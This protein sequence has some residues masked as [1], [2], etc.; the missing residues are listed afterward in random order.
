ME[1]VVELIGIRKSFGG[2]HALK[3]VD[4]ALRRGEVHALL[5]ENGAGKSTLMRVLGGEYAAEGGCVKMAGNE[6]Q[7]RGPVDALDKGIAI[8]HQEMALATDLTVAENI[9]LSE[10]PS[11]ISWRDLNRRAAKLIASL[12]FSISPSAVVSD[13][14]LAH[15]Q[16]VEIAKALSRN[17]SVMVFDEPTAVLSVQDAE[18]LLGIIRTLRDRGVGVI[19]IS[20]RLDEVF[21]IADRI[22]VMKDGASVS[23]VER[24]DVEIDDV[25]RMMVGRSLKALFGEDIDRPIGEEVLRIENLSDGRRIG[26]V[27]LTIKAGEIVGLGG[28]VGAGRTELVRMIFGAEK[29]HSGKIFLHGRQ[30]HINNP[31]AAVKAGIGLVPESRKEQGLVLDFPIRVNAT[32]SRL[33][34]LVNLFGFV[35]RA[36]ETATVGNLAARLR[37]KAGSL[38]DPASSLS[39]GNQQKVVLAKW[40]HADGDL[41]IFDEPT[42]GV[43][44][45]AKTEIYSLIKSLA[46]EGR[47][48]LVISSEHI[49]LFGLCDRIL[50]MREGELTGSLNPEDY[51]EEKLLKL[52]MVNTV[53]Q[54][55]AIA[56]SN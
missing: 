18:C 27:S 12:G 32:M 50:V 20:H 1:T 48:V 29:A 44:V 41:L 52:A 55:E 13:L 26:G 35:R 8:I 54:A 22:T 7:F 2:V 25:I 49:E 37:I 43:D 30:V 28:L 53:S 23:T 19:Y 40:F 24:K 17:A 46:A 36:A 33:G 10:I 6:Q 15:Q 34:P 3:G 45:G 47:A 56:T 5:G 21:R 16:V 39:G 11:V 14:S 9:F 38:N 51:T 4:F 31:R 42:R